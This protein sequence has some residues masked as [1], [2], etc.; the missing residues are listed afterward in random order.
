MRYKNFVILLAISLIFFSC[1]TKLTYY[2]SLKTFISSEDYIKANS[3][4][5]ENKLK[6]YG[7]KNAFLYWY[8]KGLVAH[9]AGDYKTSILAL[10]KAE[11]IAEE[12]YTKSISEETISILTS[13]ETKS[14][15]GED[16]ER[17]F[18]N[19]FQALNY[20]FLEEYESAL[21]EVRKVDHKLKTLKVNYCGKNVYKEDAFVRYLT[22][23]IYESQNELNDAFI[24]YR[25][26]ILEYTQNSKIYTFPIPKDLVLRT[27][28]MAKFLG[29][30]DEFEKIKEK[31]NI[32]VKYHDI[33]K[34]G[35]GE[36]VVIHYNGFAPYKIDH[37]I[38]MSFGEGWLYVGSVQVNS[39]EEADFRK[40]QR[41]ARSISADEQFVIAI[42]K[43][44]SVEP[45]IVSVTAEI[46][47]DKNNVV[48]EGEDTIAK[49]NLEDRISTIWARTVARAVIKY[50]LARAVS[51][52]LEKRTNDELTKW[53]IKKSIQV[54]RTT[55]EK[56][57]KRSCRILPREIRLYTK[58]LPA[59]KYKLVLKFYNKYNNLILRKNFDVNI[60]VYKKTFIPV[61][62]G[63]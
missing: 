63:I 37:F 15:Y 61:R 56:A 20:L 18:I 30:K 40:A 47:D 31:F 39:D 38:E 2:N 45:Q 23:L 51:A 46:Y 44:V 16:F 49:K 53:L 27:L 9:Y 22:G 52:E 58:K 57:D 43:F 36:L 48:S 3:L 50:V 34:S 19:I 28:T 62:T 8:D 33:Q 1:A 4:I 14:Y 26:A 59:S 54:A 11:N 5:E 17:I 24:A 25:N 32:D 60:S 42:P 55:T 21:V 29:F 6:E 7:E 13:D 10:K 12:L 35:D 41:I